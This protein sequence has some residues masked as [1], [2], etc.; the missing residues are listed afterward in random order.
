MNS[1]KLIPVSVVIPC[2]NCADTV[3]RAISSVYSQSVLPTEV[4]LVDDFSSDETYSKICEMKKF[5]SNLTIIRSEF[6]RGA[7]SAR[8]LGWD[9]A[10]QPYIAFLDADDSWH[11]EKLKLQY[12]FMIK[13]PNIVLSGHQCVLVNKSTNIEIFSDIVS[14]RKIKS[15]SILFRNPFNTPA[16]MLKREIP[17]RFRDG[18]RYA[19]DFLLWQQIVLNRFEAFLIEKPLAFVH[20]P[21]YGAGGLSKNLIK[22]E[23]GELENFFILYKNNHIG[24][25]LLVFSIYFSL[26]KFF[27]RLIFTFAKIY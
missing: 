22:M 9:Y 27:K 15:F 26:I 12:N 14:C 24:P 4:I 1:K 2:F 10:S 21:L 13:H 6:N 19:E 8:N 18:K 23:I 16:V 20:K 5:Y 11:P 17:F 25:L 7:A 3:N